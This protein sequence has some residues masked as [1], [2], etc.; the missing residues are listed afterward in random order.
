MEATIT[1]KLV[2][3]TL[4]VLLLLSIALSGAAPSVQPTGNSVPTPTSL[5]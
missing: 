1:R 4:A 5:P 2:Y 3:F